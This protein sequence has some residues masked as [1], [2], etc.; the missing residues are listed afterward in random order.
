[1]EVKIYYQKSQYFCGLL[2]KFCFVPDVTHELIDTKE[3]TDTSITCLEQLF[4]HYNWM[5]NGDGIC[6]PYFTQK[7]RT[8]KDVKHSSMSVGD[9]VEGNGKFFVV[10]GCGFKELTQAY[11]PNDNL[12]PIF[13]KDGGI[14]NY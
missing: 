5:W 1:M 9:V 10:A 3:L 12:R 7:V 8:S 4:F 11:V 14:I 6:P 2:S 13:D